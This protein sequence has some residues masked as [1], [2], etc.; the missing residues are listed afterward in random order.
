MSGVNVSATWRALLEGVV[1]S[2]LVQG[3]QWNH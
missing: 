1:G 3:L 2:G